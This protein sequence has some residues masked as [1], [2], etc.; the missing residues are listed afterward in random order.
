M[1]FKDSWMIKS[2]TFKQEIAINEI[3]NFKLQEQE[4]FFLTFCIINTLRFKRIKV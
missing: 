3:I 2:V 1:G 4:C